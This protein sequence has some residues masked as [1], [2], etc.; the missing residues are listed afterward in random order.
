MKRATIGDVAKAAGVSTKTVSR[1]LNR[2]PSVRPAT[3]DRVADAI[4]R[5]KYRPNSSAR[6][7]AGNRT[8]LLGLV[9]NANSSYITSIQNGVLEACRGEH[10]DLLIHPCRYTDPALLSEVEELVASPRVDGLI[11][12]PPVSDLKPVRELMDTLGTP[13]VIISRESIADSEWTVCTN[14]RDISAEMAAHLARLGHRRIA[15]VRSHPDHRAMANR[16]T[17]FIDG[18]AAAGLRVSES[19]VVEGDNTFE[20]GIDCALRLLRSGNRPTAIFCAND[21][22]AAGAIKAAHETGLSIPRDLSI[23]GFDD[24]PL[25]GQIWPQLTTVRQPLHDMAKLAAK[26]LIMRLRGEAGGDLKRV[27]NAELVVRDSTGAAPGGN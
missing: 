22:M 9:Y 3:K 11:L 27:I 24:I 5:L 6:M 18:M 25:A 26:L 23:A 15:F 10:Y 19:L 17:G 8:Y 2:E 16:Y 14:D 1:V 21:H 7:L 12:T 4:N 13:N 20:S